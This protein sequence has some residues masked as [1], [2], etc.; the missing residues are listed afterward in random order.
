MTCQ[1]AICG[2]N[3]TRDAAPAGERAATRVRIGALQQ[4]TSMAGTSA[5][6]ASCQRMSAHSPASPPSRIAVRTDCAWRVDS[7]VLKNTAPVSIEGACEYE[8][9]TSE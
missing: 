4:R 9:E 2:E 5:K 1:T 6:I 8:G 7:Q 3:T